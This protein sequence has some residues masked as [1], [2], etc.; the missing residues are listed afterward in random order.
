MEYLS[1]L[2]KMIDINEID[3]LKIYISNCEKDI[4]HKQNKIEELL[5][6]IINQNKN[7]NILLD[8]INNNEIHIQNQYRIIHELQEYI[9]YLEQKNNMLEIEKLSFN[10]GVVFS[11][12]ETKLNTINEIDEMI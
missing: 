6:N 2:R 7:Y 10:K 8:K 3:T 12:L 1:L 9:K 4:Q 5:F 11:N